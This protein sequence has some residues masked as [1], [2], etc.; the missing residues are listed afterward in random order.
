[1]DLKLTVRR[2]GGVDASDVMVTCDAT[3]T[4]SSIARAIAERDPNKSFKGDPSVFTIRVDGPG[5][6]R[7]LRHDMPLAESGVRSGDFVSLVPSSG[8]YRDGSDGR[9]T[10]TTLLIESGPNAGKRF[11]LAAGGAMIG[12]DPLAEVSL[13]DPLVSKRHARLS[14]GDTLEIFDLGSVNGVEVDGLVT[15]R[16]ILRPG[17]EITIGDTVLR[18]EHHRPSGETGTQGEVAFNRSPYLN[19]VYKGVEHEAPDVPEHRDQQPFPVFMLLIMLLMS[20]M[21]V[22]MMRT[23]RSGGSPFMIGFYLLMPIM[24][25]GSWLPARR[26][27]KRQSEA[28]R[29]N[30]HEALHHL[31]SQLTIERSEEVAKRLREHVSVTEVVQSASAR[32]NL[33]WAMRPDR[34]G[35]L[36]LR[37]GVAALPSR[38]EVKMPS[39]KKAI[40]ELQDEL[41]AVVDKHATVSPVPVIASLPTIGALGVAG[42]RADVLG[43][44]RGL[45]VQAVGLHSPAEMLIAAVLP[46]ESAQEW[47][48]LKWLPHTSP[49]AS[50]IEGDLLA[51]GPTTC[52]SLV[53]RLNELIDE[54]LEERADGGSASDAAATSVVVLIEDAAPVERP[55][56]ISLAERGRD[57]GVYVIWLADTMLRLPAACEI[58]F[59]HDPAQHTVATGI[60]EDGST[61]VP[62]DGEPLPR[63]VAE[64]VAR[65]LC[66]VIDAGAATDEAGDVPMRVSFLSEVG[67]ELADSPAAVVDRWRQSDSLP[68]DPTNV[69]RRRKKHNLAA[70]IGAAAHGPLTL[71][72][73]GQGPHA[74]VGGTT[75]AGK[76]EFLQSWVMGLATMHSPARVTFLFV[77]YKGGAAFSECVKLPHTVG[78]V[79]DLTMHLVHRALRSLNAELRYREH[80]LN[81]KKAKDVLELETRGDPDCPPSLVIVV[82]EFAALVAEVP[83]FVDGVV[84]VAQRGRSLGLHLIL[85]TQRPAGVIRDN[86]RANT[87]LRI[88]LRMAD[89]S[90]SHDVIGSKLAATFDPAIPGRGVAKTG[91]GRLSLFQSAY[92]GGWTT[93][94][95]PPPPITITDL[96]VGPA[97]QWEITEGVESGPVGAGGSDDQGPNDLKRLVESTREAAA[98]AGIPEPRKPWLPELAPVYDMARSPQSRTDR[99]LIFGIADDPDGQ[100]QTSIAFNPDV[101]GNMSAVGTGGTGKSTFLRTIAVAAGLTQRGG[102]CHVY[103]LDFGSRG[104]SMLEPLPHVGAV[105]YGDDTERVLRLLRTLR[106][107]IDRRAEEYA[108]V[109]AGTI[110]DYRTLA[111]KPDEPRIFL[112]VDGMGAFRKQ[113]EDGP[114]LAAYNQFLSI[115]ADGRQLGVHVIVTA[116]RSGSIPTALGSVIQRRL[117][118]RLADDS[119]YF[120]AGAPPDGF[121]ADSPPGRA[122]IDMQELQVVVLG[123]VANTVQ[124]SRAIQSLAVQLPKSRPWPD[125]PG[126]GRLPDVVRSEDLPVLPGGPKVVVAMSDVDLAPVAIETNPPLLII[127]PPRSGKTTALTTVAQMLDRRSERPQMV[128]IGP[129]RSSLP[130]VVGWD[131]I[132]GESEIGDDLPA[133]MAELEGSDLQPASYAFFIEAADRLSQGMEDLALAKLVR[134]A[135]ETGQLVVADA[136]NQNARS[137]TNLLRALR[138]YRHGIALVPDQYDGDG[139]F[140]TLFPRI[141]RAQYP[142]GRGVYVHEGKLQ[143]VQ[144]ALPFEEALDAYTG[145]QR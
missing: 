137:S 93:A 118:F 74:L 104:L 44:A 138:L 24:M 128:Y 123:G 50:P 32:A 72:L 58:F 140:N 33:L 131:R 56:L 139:V 97:A 106:Q 40:P 47:D 52:P 9:S 7:V 75:G 134:L 115:A 22:A 41:A 135:V 111:G 27:A 15:A 42:S 98:S 117:V 112:L 88:A 66:P 129:G 69:G 37:L 8:R 77:D 116:D 76:S 51:A 48:W 105:I 70:Y 81:A 23:Q 21:M 11:N 34:H 78:L 132:V 13:S 4:A 110:T 38:S 68:P 86:L 57:V 101:D 84:N 36:E 43:A 133:L 100:R 64:R 29:K 126:V 18:V 61:I 67:L 31:D 114:T 91:P 63:D 102:P 103:C 10:V 143:R 26:Q 142:P 124:Q 3:A 1:M 89:E 127:G 95:P 122:F 60:I 120:T 80:I 6:T 94:E 92:V 96:A 107:T 30:F 12:R 82:D 54:R 90:D 28:D 144:V 99:E 125:A 71:D 46:A 59:T 73:R 85:A 87:N 83:E 35:F 17:D 141:N 55:A 25:L 79:T 45:L 5:A 20:G 109:R 65:D 14:I 19:P 130:T 16:T 62:M 53:S 39:V 119:E 145:V 121:T 136:E 2:P 113:Y 49:G 108:K